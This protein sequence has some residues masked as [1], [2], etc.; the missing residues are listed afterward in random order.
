[1]ILASALG[2]GGALSSPLAHADLG[3]IVMGGIA[4]H[5]TNT[6]DAALVW[7]PNLHWWQMGDWSFSLLGE[8]HAATI[9]NTEGDQ[10]RTLAAFGATPVFRIGKD[11]GLIRPF[12]EAGVGVRLLSGVHLNDAYDI[13]T[14]FQFADMAGVGFKFG[15]RGEY[16]FGYRFQ[17]LSNASIKHPNPGIN[18]QQIYIGYMF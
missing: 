5:H 1:M 8:L 4:D 13:S 12:F 10:P 6:V 2:V 7:D 18:F 11:S 14:S 9:R 3:V 17:H 16:E 15:N